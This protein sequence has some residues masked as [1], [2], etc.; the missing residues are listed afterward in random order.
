MRKLA[1]GNWK[2]NGLDADLNGFASLPNGPSELLI[3]PPATMISALRVRFPDHIQLGAQ[4]CHAEV[5]GAYTGEISAHMLREAGASHV[6]LGHSERRDAFD[7]SDDDVAEK[8]E[9]AYDSGLI[10]IICVGESLSERDS[11]NTLDVIRT[12]LAAS[13]PDAATPQTTIIAYEPIW[14][15]GTGRTPTL[16]QIAEVH[17]FIHTTL[18]SRFGATF[19]ILYGGSMKPGNAAD[20][21]ALPHVSGGLIGG[22][23][24][25]PDDFGAIAQ[26]LS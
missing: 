16:E 12:S 11:G 14:A 17:D 26:A 10:A 9:A 7:E 23:S 24:L 8:A 5:S 22:A 6:I 4:D 18:Q 15:I 1:A 13:V 20:I 2:M 21:C 25:S 19:R 3:C